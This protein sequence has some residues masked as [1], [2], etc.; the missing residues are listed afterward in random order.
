[1]V[2]ILSSRGTGRSY[3][4]ARY[5][6]ENNCNILVAYYNGVKYMRAILDD[7]FK[8][9]GYVIDK[10]DGSDDGYSYYYIFRRRFELEQHTVKIYTA[11]DAIRFKELSRAEN[12]VIDDADR[13]LEYLFRPYK[14]KV[15]TM[16]VGNG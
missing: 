3:Q 1:M 13:V 12:I 6:I 14:L 10:Q 11:S 15:I 4:I 16:E 2:K 5:A 8:S 9:D 7:I